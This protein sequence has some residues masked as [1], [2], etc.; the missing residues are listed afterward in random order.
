[1]VHKGHGIRVA[2]LVSIGK[3]WCK[4]NANTHTLHHTTVLSDQFTRQS[5]NT[6]PYANC[7]IHTNPQ[8][9]KLYKSGAMTV[10]VQDPWLPL[11][12]RP[13][14]PY[15]QWPVLIGATTGS[16]WSRNIDL[17]LLCNWSE[18]HLFCPTIHASK[19][20]D[21]KVWEEKMHD[22]LYASTFF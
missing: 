15:K 19:Q 14:S 21:T 13:A 1:V 22:N 16:M 9:S 20:V 17:L 11:A 8:R 6:P 12:A 4:A 7:V 5:V 18:S 2:S 10:F 3:A